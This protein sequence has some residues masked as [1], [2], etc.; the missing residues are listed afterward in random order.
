[1]ALGVKVSR[2]TDLF[3]CKYRDCSHFNEG[4]CSG[5]KMKEMAGDCNGG[6]VKR[7]EIGLGPRG[8]FPPLTIDLDSTDSALTESYFLL[9][10]L[11]SPS[12]TMCSSTTSKPGIYCSE[13]SVGLS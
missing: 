10:C 3:F 13:D 4:D 5:G 12:P 6:K 9:L 2:G 11:G 7:R 8:P 1:M